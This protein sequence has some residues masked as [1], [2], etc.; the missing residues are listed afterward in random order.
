MI[1]ASLEAYFSRPIAPTRR[2]ALGAHD[3]PVEHPPGFGGI[4][5]GGV[6]ARYSPWLEE[7]L[8]DEVVPLIREL[9][10]RNRVPQPRLRHRYQTDH[11]GLTRCRH[12]LVASG[13]ALDFLFDEENG[14]PAQHVLAA[15]YA[16]AAMPPARRHAILDT[17]ETAFRWR[18]L[19]GQRFISHL[20]GNSVPVPAM[21]VG[22][23]VQWAL[24][25]LDLIDDGASRSAVQQ[26]FRA[27]LMDAHPD[28]G[29]Q[30]DGAAER[31]AELTE[32]RRILLGR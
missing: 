5:L 6:V 22:D 25:V 2:I 7:D 18:G 23:P 26:A 13:E 29:G 16:A 21:S 27:R 19:V 30:R 9:R 17:L 20:C 10:H 15:V 31:I 14:T 24:G 8:A 12:R 32:A 1:V 4:L 3:L 28:R 11:V